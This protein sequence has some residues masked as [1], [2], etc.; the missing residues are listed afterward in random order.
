MPK[1]EDHWWSGLI[2]WI[3]ISIFFVILLFGLWWQGRLI[4]QI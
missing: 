4:A 2:Q 1:P 3:V